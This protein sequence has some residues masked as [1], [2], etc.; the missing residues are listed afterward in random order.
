MTAWLL[1][2]LMALP[3]GTLA[4]LDVAPT[5]PHSVG[6]RLPLYGAEDETG[7][8]IDLRT[9]KGPILVN[10]WASWCPPCERELPV[11]AALH[12]TWAPRGLTVVGVSVDK[13]KTGPK[14]LIDKYAL[15]F[16]VLYDH[17]NVAADA[18]AVKLLPTTFLYDHRHRLVFFR[19]DVLRHD[20]PELKAALE[21]AVT[22][23]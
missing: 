6:A 10:V 18:L 12:R 17:E 1:L 5:H 8:A 19:A 14:R 11:L 13:I 2:W 20:D 4:G 22:R 15:P 21:K 7:K 23:P 9:I 16:Q 3:P